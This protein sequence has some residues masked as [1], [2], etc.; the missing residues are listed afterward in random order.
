MGPALLLMVMLVTEKLIAATNQIDQPA[1][2]LDPGGANATAGVGLDLGFWLVLAAAGVALGLFLWR[3]WYRLRSAPP[4]PA[5]FG[6]LAGGA[7]FTAMLLLGAGGAAAAQAAWDI[8]NSGE[9]AMLSLADQAKVLLGLY[10]GQA[11]VVATFAWLLLTVRKPATSERRGPLGAVVLGAGALALFWP[12][13]AATGALVGEVVSWLRQ[14][15]LSPIAH[16]TLGLLLDSDRDAWFALMVGLVVIVAPISE[17][18]MYRG[19]IQETLRRLGLSRWTAIAL[20]SGAFAVM[21]STV[22]PLHAV[23][24]L[25]VLSLGLGWIYERTGRLSASI[26]MHVLFNAGNLVIAF[27]LLG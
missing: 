6:P 11:L 15:D 24:S 25:F 8:E 9:L 12:M 4:R 3:R 26:T 7:L 19:V 23:L 13:T 21:H 5:A 14:E 18:V 10:G 22:A 27:T 16:H 20:T 17:E 2:M 1:E